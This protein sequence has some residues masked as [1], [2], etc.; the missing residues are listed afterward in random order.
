ML[1]STPDMYIQVRSRNGSSW[2]KS[3]TCEPMR[4][5]KRP[6]PTLKTVCSSSAGMASSQYQV[7]GSPVASTMI[8]RTPIDSTICWNS[9]IT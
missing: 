9:M 5:T 2:L 1:N 7:S 3:L 4:A 6:T 8:T